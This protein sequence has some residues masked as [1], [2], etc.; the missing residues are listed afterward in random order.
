MAIPGLAFGNVANVKGMG[1]DSLQP[2]LCCQPEV[3]AHVVW[4]SPAGEAGKEMHLG[5]EG[6]EGVS[7]DRIKQERAAQV[8]RASSEV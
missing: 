2:A 1:V 6:G 4:P 5:P 7:T 8:Y 3:R